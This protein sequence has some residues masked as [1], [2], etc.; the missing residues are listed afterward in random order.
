MIKIS[1]ALREN[2]RM[3]K[4][5]NLQSLIEKIGL[6]YTIKVTQLVLTYEN[7]TEEA[8][9]LLN[10]DDYKL[11]KESERDFHVTAYIK[12]ISQVWK[13]ILFSIL[14]ILLTYILMKYS[15]IK[16]L[17]VSINDNSGYLFYLLIDIFTIL[18]YTLQLLI[19]GFFWIPFIV[20]FSQL[21]YIL[22]HWVQQFYYKR[23]FSSTK[24]GFMVFFY[25][26][27]LPNVIGY[28]AS[29]ITV[30][31][32]VWVFF[33][34]LIHRTRP[35]SPEDNSFLRVLGVM[36]IAAVPRVVNFY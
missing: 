5:K 8:M 19:Q 10:E 1:S 13:L 9:M 29:M 32:L 3:V 12:P 14:T 2:I 36:I 16:S 30:I 24:A 31:W 21:G 35:R 27:L 22:K 7:D 6:V 23:I 25:L 33:H 20:S 18:K 15:A 11:I 4:P 17:S 34:V 28:I 26:N